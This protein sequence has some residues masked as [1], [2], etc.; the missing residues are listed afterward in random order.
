[1]TMLNSSYY[2]TIDPV[3]LQKLKDDLIAAGNLGSSPAWVR[4]L[5]WD[6]W[7]MLDILGSKNWSL[8]DD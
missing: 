1:M 3:E 2:H 8:A 7:E 4:K 6:S 5:C